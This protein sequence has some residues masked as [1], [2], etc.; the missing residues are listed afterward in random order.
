ME[1]QS[2]ITGVNIIIFHSMTEGRKLYKELYSVVFL[3]FLGFLIQKVRFF[4]WK[5]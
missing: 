4:F 1:N 3:A 5:R 2:E